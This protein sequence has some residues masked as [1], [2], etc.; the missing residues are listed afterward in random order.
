MVEVKA[1]EAKRKA[2]DK[3]ENEKEK[4]EEDI[5]RRREDEGGESTEWLED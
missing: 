4:E 2:G 1:S 5:K 3:R